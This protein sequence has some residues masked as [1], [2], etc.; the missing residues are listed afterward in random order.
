MSTGASPGSTA[1]R[2]TIHRLCG[3][4]LR[5]ENGHSGLSPEHAFYY[6]VDDRCYPRYYSPEYSGGPTAVQEGHTDQDPTGAVGEDWPETAWVLLAVDSSGRCSGPCSSRSWSSPWCMSSGRGPQSAESVQTARWRCFENDTHAVPSV[7]RS[8][9]SDGA[10]SW[11][12]AGWG[13]RTGTAHTVERTDA[14]DVFL[15][16]GWGVCLGVCVGHPTP[17]AVAVGTTRAYGSS[18]GK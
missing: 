10:D 13:M 15:R 2:T 6:P 11:G 16:I 7:T 8:S 18:I 1:V 3:S 4:F 14:C 12:T 5:T 17:T 9:T